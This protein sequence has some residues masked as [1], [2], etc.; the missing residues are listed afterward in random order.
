MARAIIITGG[1]LDNVKARLRQAQQM[2][3]ERL[4]VILRC[5]H[6]YESEAWGFTASDNFLNQAIELDTDLTPEELLQGVQA[7]E[8]ELGRDRTAEAAIKAANGEAYSSRKIDIDI[9]FYDDVVISTPELTIP[10]PLMHE[11]DFVLAP[12]SEIA[13]SKIHP[14]FDKTVR[15][16]RGELHARQSMEK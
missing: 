14:I 13:P 12:L 2:I 15:E 3:N 6:M 4:G 9:L 8:K 10:H 5:S 7:I 11:R 16:L 1:N